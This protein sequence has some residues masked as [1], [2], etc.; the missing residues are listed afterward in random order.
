MAGSASL[1]ALAEPGDPDNQNLSHSSNGND[2]GAGADA[3][4]DGIGGLK[5]DDQQPFVSLMN[6]LNKPSG[7]SSTLCNFNTHV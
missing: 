1:A 2:D 5:T 7:F 4:E 6:R 3:E